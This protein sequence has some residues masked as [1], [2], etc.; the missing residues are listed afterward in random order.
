MMDLTLYARLTHFGMDSSR[1]S[2]ETTST[3]A[4]KWIY[5]LQG[6]ICQDWSGLL[7]LLARPARTILMELRSA[8]R[9][10]QNL[11]GDEAGLT[12]AGSVANVTLAE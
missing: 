3:K 9:F 8:M 1:S 11:Q 5:T 12:L 6:L 2:S 7:W 4:R 10:E